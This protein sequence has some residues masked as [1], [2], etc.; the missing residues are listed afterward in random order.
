MKVKSEEYECY[1]VEVTF[2]IPTT[3]PSVCPKLS[4]RSN[5][6]TKE[7]ANQL[8]TDALSY[9]QTL[10]AQPMIMDIIMWFKENLSRYC[11][12]QE[13]SSQNSQTQEVKS[14]ELLWTALLHLDH[15][16][17]KAKYTKTIQKWV[18]EL[19]L[20]GC[21]IFCDKLIL[22]LLQGHQQDIKVPLHTNATVKKL[23]LYFCDYI[24]TDKI[25]PGCVICAVHFLEI[26]IGITTTN[27]LKRCVFQYLQTSCILRGNVG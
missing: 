23:L 12:S 9:A 11:I 7:N 14:E 25:L 13:E 21:L 19:K 1:E 27:Y 26:V 20:S 24:S 22:I 4:L 10:I 18:A 3:Y 2:T 16:R 15:M 6:L 8:K 17:A 5:V